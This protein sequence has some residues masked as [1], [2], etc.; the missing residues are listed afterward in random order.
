MKTS[1]QKSIGFIEKKLTQGHWKSGER[2]P[3]AQLLA[4][5]VHVD[6]HAMVAAL[7]MLKV[8]GKVTI[9]KRLGIF[10][11]DKI[12]EN[13]PAKSSYGNKNEKLR[14]RIESDIVDQTF[15]DKI[16]SIGELARRYNAS[17][18]LCRKVIK[19][20]I[21]EE[22]IFKV[23]RH[24]EISKK[25]RANPF[26]TICLISRGHG[27][28]HITIFNTRIS[29]FITAAVQTCGRNGVTLSR[30][31][32][33][34]SNRE[35]V[36]LLQATIASGNHIGYI[37]YLP[38]PYVEGEII[39]DDF[40][41]FMIPFASA[42]AAPVVFISET[43]QLKLPPAFGP[44]HPARIIVLNSKN[45]G[46][47]VGQFLMNNGI[48]TAAY[49]SSY[50]RDGNWSAQ[51]YAG[52]CAAFLR[53]PNTSKPALFMRPIHPPSMGDSNRKVIDSD[54][55]KLEALLEE[56]SEFSNLARRAIMLHYGESW[57]I[58]NFAYQYHEFLPLFG[59]LAADNTSMAWVCENDALAFSADYFF[60]KHPQYSMPMLVGFDNSDLAREGLFISYE[61][62]FAAN[63]RK[64]IDYI[65]NPY[66]PLYS[67]H[68][69]SMECNGH[70]I[71]W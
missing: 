46:E 8:Q 37:V 29:N 3:P 47:A 7:N 16:P 58:F 11:G 60:K 71:Q 17:P 31:G 51:R 23:G 6:I 57:N 41:R 13:L 27:H 32:L 44:R 68:T 43:E 19:S 1:I 40:S 48:H 35:S 14:I 12:P 61:F 59:Q 69:K 9:V 24:F 65:L 50:F 4:K 36:K 64:A 33:D 67:H 2:L 22:R 5:A 18:F 42:T 26:A 15:D 28:E 56:M 63:A 54:R 20:L 53:Q 62:D 66:S 34:F 21:A 39:D 10:A 52:L 30:L 70:I 45:A 25:A 38:D 49:L 55:L